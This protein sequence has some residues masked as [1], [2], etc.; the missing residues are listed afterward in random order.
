[1]ILID[2]KKNM[3]K[4]LFDIVFALFTLL[5]FSWLLLILWCIAIVDTCTNGVFIQERIGQFGKKFKIYK[6]RTI[7]DSASS[8]ERRISKTAQFLRKYKLDELPQLFNVLKGNMSIVGTRPDLPGYYDLLEGENRKILELKPGLTSLA[9]LK[10]YNEEKLLAQQQ[11]PLWFNDQVIFPD[12]VRLNLLYFYNHS[13]W[14]DIKIIMKT[15]SF[16]FNK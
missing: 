2:L 9:S 4:R 1:M 7:R 14:G 3:A 10:Y 8:E 11:D 5:L 16:I 6:F 13:F 15:F 12:K